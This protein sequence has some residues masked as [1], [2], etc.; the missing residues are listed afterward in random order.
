MSCLPAYLYRVLSIIPFNM[1]NRQKHGLFE[2]N[3]GR[4]LRKTEPDC[5]KPRKIGHF[6]M[7]R[8][9]VLSIPY[10]SDLTAFRSARRNN[11]LIISHTLVMLA[12]IWHDILGPRAV[13]FEFLRHA[14]LEI[15]A[16]TGGS[17]SQRGLSAMKR[18]LRGPIRLIKK[19]GRRVHHLTARFEDSPSKLGGN[20]YEPR[21]LSVFE[22]FRS[23]SPRAEP[24][25]VV[26][27]L[28]VKT[29]VAYHPD[30]R[31]FN[32]QVLDGR[33]EDGK[34]FLGDTAEWIG[35]LKC[36]LSARGR[37]VAMELGA[38]WGPWLVA[39]AKAALSR[40]ITDLR[41]YGVEGD[42]ARI[43][44]M[45]Q[46]FLDNGL[47]PDQHVLLQAAVG[48]ERGTVRWP[49]VDN[50]D[51]DWGSRP[52]QDGDAESLAR[53]AD[54]RGRVFQE[55]L[56]VELIPLAE[57]VAREPLWDLVH[58]DVQG[59]EFDICRS[60]TDVI[61]ERVRWL[62]VGTHSRKVEGDLINHLFHQGWVLEN[63][64]PNRFVFQPNSPTLEGMGVVDG[65]QVWRNPRLVI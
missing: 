32:G 60:A 45:R 14:G 49:K 17:I 52:V 29:R 2:K 39:G 57:L 59:W 42:P 5:K 24:G 1:G 46:H 38:G 37:F 34:A 54:Y 13:A 36:V 44:F 9:L 25:V 18:P 3:R 20:G 7:L 65:S 47:D 12:A 21:E 10:R 28:G 43:D 62:I 53:A 4:E 19:L 31:R 58:I 16:M 23:P 35:L 64:K 63:E 55:C 26:D 41:L 8:G 15:R 56:E 61:N 33:I 11:P 6:C 27:F 40:G 30:F 22:A 50:P 48:T 51:G